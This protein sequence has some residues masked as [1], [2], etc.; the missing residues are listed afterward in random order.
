[1]NDILISDTIYIYPS[2]GFESRVSS[3]R[4]DGAREKVGEEG[5]GGKVRVRKPRGGGK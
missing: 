5:Q 1:M 2:L 4:R 3:P